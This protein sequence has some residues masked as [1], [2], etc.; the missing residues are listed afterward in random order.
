MKSYLWSC[1][2]TFQYLSTGP[3][4]ANKYYSSAGQHEEKTK[5]NTGQIKFSAITIKQQIKL[6]L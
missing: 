1:F 4:A 2:G 5:K 6:V 3:S